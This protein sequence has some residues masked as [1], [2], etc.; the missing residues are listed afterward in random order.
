[1]RRSAL[2]LLL[3]AATTVS[4]AG[5]AE[6]YGRP[7]RGLSAVPLQTIVKSPGR[8]ADRDVRV[9]GAARHD[10]DGRTVL[11]DGTASLSI[12]ADGEFSLPDASN[13]GQ[14]T[15]EGRVEVGPPARLVASGVEVQ[16]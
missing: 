5:T 15:A 8:F 12:V 7:L 1:M 2:L 10:A 6:L 9:T 3:L 4:L 14:W 11:T 16:K 13:G